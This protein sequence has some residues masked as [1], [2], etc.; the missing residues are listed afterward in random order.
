MRPAVAVVNLVLIIGVWAIATG[1]FRIVN[2]IRLRK[3][4]PNEGMLILSGIAALLFGGIVL[5]RPAASIVGMMWAVGIYGLVV[6][7]LLLAFS[8]RLRGSVESDISDISR[9]A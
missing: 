1:L 7:G 5:W 2:A 9:A 3:L 8:I 4:I 6:G